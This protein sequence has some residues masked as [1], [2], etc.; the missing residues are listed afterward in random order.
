MKLQLITLATS[1]IFPLGGN[2]LP[3]LPIP[4]A[5]AQIQPDIQKLAQSITVKVFSGEN[6][7]SGTIIKKD[8]EVY[9]IITNRHVLA[10]NQPIT[11]QTPDGNIVEATV[12]EQNLE[13]LDAVFLQFRSKNN[14]AV[15]SLGDFS[16]NSQIFAAGFPTEAQGLVVVEGKLSLTPDKPFQDGY[17]L[18]Y[19]GDIQKGMSGGPIITADGK[20]IGINGIHAEPLWGNPYTYSDGTEPTE[21]EKE[22]FARYNWAIPL[23]SIPQLASTPVN[24]TTTP[25]SSSLI[26]EQARNIAQ[27]ITVKIDNVA[28]KTNGSGVIIARE[29][30]VYTVLTAAHVVEEKKGGLE[31]VIT[32][33]DGKTY[34]VKRENIKTSLK[35]ADLAV[36]QFTSEESY[37]VATFAN[38]RLENAGGLVF[39]AGFDGSNPNQLTFSVGEVFNDEEEGKLRVKDSLSL[40]NG[41]GVVYTNLTAGGMSGG[42]VLD[43]RGNLVAIHGKA[44]GE[45]TINEASGESKN[46]YLGYSLG[47]PI[48]VFLS[49]VEKVEM[50]PELLRVYT[51]DEDAPPLTDEERQ[52]I[53]A[54]LPQLKEPSSNNPIDWVNYGNQLWRRKE[55]DAALAAFD[56]AIA[57]DAGFYQAWYAKGVTLYQQGLYEEALVAFDEAIKASGETFALSWGK[58]GETLNALQRYE[59]ALVA[60]DKAIELEQV[61]EAEFSYYMGRGYALAEGLKRNEEAVESYTQAIAINEHSWAYNDRG[62]AYLNLGNLDA[63]IADLNKALEINPE[64]ALAYSNRGGAYLTLGNL[65]A[66]MAD[67]NK[68]LEINPELALAYSNR[69][70][71]YLN[72]GNYEAAMADFNKALEINPELAEAYG[73]RG[74]AYN[75]LGNLDAAMA[76][77]NKALEINPELAEAYGNRGLAYNNLGNLDAAMADFNKALEINPELALAYL[78]RGLAYNNLGNLDAAMADFNKALE[79]NP[80][81]ALAYN[82]RGVTYNNLGNYEAAMADFNKALEINPELAEAYLN[83]GAAYLNL[84]N[85]DAAMA[86]FNKALEIN[87]E[88]ALAYNNRGLAHKN[89]G[90]LDAAI[91][92]YN[93][94]LEINP[95]LAEAYLHRGL[96]YNKLGNYEAAIAD[97]NKAIALNEN[98]RPAMVNI[99]LIKYEQGEI[100]TAI[101]QWEKSVKINPESAEPQLAISVALYTQGKTEEGLAKAEAALKLDKN[102]GNL[103]HLKKNLWGDKLLADAEKLLNHPQIQSLLSQ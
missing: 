19:T 21:A 78:N 52:A 63:A 71:A 79:I 50:K 49:Q 64:L 8:G 56:K 42:P 102:F 51:T 47:V 53:F 93:K 14:Y 2:F 1:L 67:L 58:R 91:A 6:T 59:E 88:L 33:P 11:I 13:G 40:S 36:L 7:G 80:E 86:D 97:Y 25:S 99:G 43:I 10:K 48:K 16:P 90:N 35:G 66:A 5:I 12:L 18:G 61:T 23:Q 103:E 101:Q 69:G 74:G 32:T 34:P 94:A 65:D 57:L 9:T 96:A 82:N 3:L 68:A 17:E 31:L 30:N 24:P 27:E 77:F 62:Y 89:L 98:F 37:S 85:L 100:E 92:D 29:G 70:G 4:P 44:D 75:D 81:L 22:L 76:D 84:G 38:Y 72:L 46:I 95:E 39:V 54:A 55:Y 15:A 28:A 87:P 73:N 20:V 60:F 83:R 45:T 41:Y 26:L